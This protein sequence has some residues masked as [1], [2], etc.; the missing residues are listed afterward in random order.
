VSTHVVPAEAD[1]RRADVALAG[2]LGTSRN[3]AAARFDDAGVSRDGR[4]LRRSDVVHAGDR[5]V[6]ADPPA[7]APARPAPPLPP[8][9]WRDE[10]LLVLA[11]PPGLVVHPG[12]GH[13]DGTLVDALRAADVP[14]A[15]RGGAD[16]PGV[17]HRLDK[18]TS[19]LLVV[20]CT[21]RAHAGLVDLLRRRDV[22][23]RYLALVDGTLPGRTGRV[24]APIGRDPR[25]RQRFAAVEGGKPAVTH[26]SVRATGRT[27]DA[28]VTLVACRLETGRTHQIRVHLAF[29]G[30]PVVG[31]RRYG[32]SRAVA[33][34]LGLER[35]FLHAATLGFVHPVTGERVE[36]REPL[37]PDLRSAAAAAGIA[38]DVDG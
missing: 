14:L 28:A 34:R 22:D 9:R 26:W 37:P 21:D 4:P 1:G 25:D 20:A 36:V 31:D 19:G 32:A 8:V 30:A 3:R 12:A 7:P 15:P 17:V 2:L 5:L 33:E 23:R 35:P 16:R 10:H 11:K 38:V 27:G 24:D 18:D 6:L 29:A 13:P